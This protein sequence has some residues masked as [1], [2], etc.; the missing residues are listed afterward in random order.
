MPV[1]LRGGLRLFVRLYGLIHFSNSLDLY[2]S[3]FWTLKPK[4]YW[5]H[6]VCWPNC[7]NI[8][9]D[10]G[11]CLT[12]VVPLDSAQNSGLVE[13][14]NH[15]NWTSIEV[16]R[17]CFLFSMRKNKCSRGSAGVHSSDSASARRPILSRIFLPFTENGA[18]S[19]NTYAILLFLEVVWIG[20]WRRIWW[21]TRLTVII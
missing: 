19:P 4:L 9:F 12:G 15:R 10:F 11:P 20:I 16:Y 8:S 2:S 21:Y 17:P 6:L 5:S 13:L 14:Q 1:V 18:V 3:S 7:V